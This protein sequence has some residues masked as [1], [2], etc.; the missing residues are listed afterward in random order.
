[1]ESKFH[2]GISLQ[3]WSGSVSHCSRCRSSWQLIARLWERTTQIG[4]CW[5]ESLQFSSWSAAALD[6]DTVGT[7][8]SNL[9]RFARQHAANLAPEGTLARCDCSIGH[10]WSVSTSTRGWHSSRRR[11]WRC[12]SPVPFG[13]YS[14]HAPRRSR[15]RNFLSGFAIERLQS[16]TGSKVLAGLVPLAIFAASHYRQGIG[17][18]VAVFVLGGILTAFYMKFRDLLANITAHFLG[19]FVLHVALRVSGG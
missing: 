10:R 3:P 14:E 1:M 8:A 5:E 12:V 9:H 19:D 6:S 15:R 16:L 13:R 18:I 2:G 17:G 4:K 7:A 11:S